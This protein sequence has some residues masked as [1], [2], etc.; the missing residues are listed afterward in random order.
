MDRRDRVRTRGAKTGIGIHLR[1][2]KPAGS[3]KLTRS[4]KVPENTDQGCWFFPEQETTRKLGLSKKTEDLESS[5]G[6]GSIL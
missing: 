5:S 6:C 3:C 2:E 1:L 4:A